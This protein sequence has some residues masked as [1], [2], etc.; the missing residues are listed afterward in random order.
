M[1]MIETINLT[2]KYGELVA[3]NNLNLTIEEGDCFGFIGPNG[4]GKTTTIKILATLLK[5]TWGEARIDG[6]VVGYQNPQIRPMIGYVP[7]FMGAYD[8]M[9][10]SEYLQFF[11][12]CYDIHGKQREQVVRDVLDLTDLNYKANAEVNGLSRGMKQRLSIARVLLH[13]PKV[14]LLDEPAS[15]LD[16]RARIEI[17]ELLKELRRMGKTI[18]ISSHIL[19][20]LSE[21]CNTV[22]IIE[23]GELL[24]SGSV[25]EIMTRA[26]MGVVVHVVV[27]DRYEQAAKLLAAVKG[28]TKVDV[29]HNNGMARIDVTIDP[30]SGLMVSELPNRLIAQ[31]F[32]L[33]SM[34]QEQVNLET[35]FMRLTKGLVA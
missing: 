33:S 17:R 6:K 5:P 11:A 7:D 21:L 27:E 30:E 34:Q 35:A 22:G 19:H 2:K 4:A 31:G 16:P 9:V 28:I 10:V 8:D 20:E 29:T 3:L 23:Q 25:H 24:F 14:L 13:D 32:R 18:I 15:G 12:A 1:S 26:S